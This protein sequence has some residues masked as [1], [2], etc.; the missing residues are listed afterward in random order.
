MGS[1][2]SKLKMLKKLFKIVPARVWTPGS[3]AGVTG[4]TQPVREFRVAQNKTSGSAC[5]LLS[6]KKALKCIFSTYFLGLLLNL[7]SGSCRSVFLQ[8]LGDI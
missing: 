1:D 6:K 4:L 5:E 8:A 2:I 7:G 3:V